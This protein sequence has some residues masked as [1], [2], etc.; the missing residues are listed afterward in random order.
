MSYIP[1]NGI[2]NA[3]P[4][5]LTDGQTYP[6][7]LDSSGKLLLSGTITLP[8]DVNPGTYAV[9]DSAMPA[10]PQT[11]PTSGEYRASP[12]TYTDGD[13][14]VTQTDA[15]GNTKVR[16]QFVPQFEDDTAGVAKVEHQYLYSRKTADGQ[17]KGAA[18]FIHTVSYAPIAAIPTAGL[19]AVYDNTAGSGTPIFSKWVFATDPGDSFVLDVVA[20]TG[21]YVEFDATLAD[22][23]VTVSY[24]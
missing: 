8:S 6:P 2:Y 11:I 20:S 24:R 15:T 17:V 21:I 9:D 18:G 13:V 1:S 22:V 5:S 14:T 4:P 3:T 7:A 16:E 10:T 12:T 19:F 23:Q